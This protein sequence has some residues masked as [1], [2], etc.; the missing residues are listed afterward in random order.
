[1]EWSSMEVT[2][3]HVSNFQIRKLKISYFYTDPY[4]NVCIYVYNTA[5][6]HYSQD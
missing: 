6:M 3:R 1:M 4:D 5:C 2:T